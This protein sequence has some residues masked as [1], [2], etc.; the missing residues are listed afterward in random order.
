MGIPR[1]LRNVIFRQILLYHKEIQLDFDLSS[2]WTSAEDYWMFR[3]M[4]SAFDE[5]EPI[6]GNRTEAR[7]G[8][9]LRILRVCKQAY[10]EGRLIFYGDNRWFFRHARAFHRLFLDWPE[11]YTGCLSTKAGLIRDLTIWPSKDDTTYPELSYMEFIEVMCEYLPALQHLQII[12][13]YS[14]FRDRAQDRKRWIGLVGI[15][16]NVVAMAARITRNHPSLKKAIYSRRSGRLREVESVSP[17][18]R[19]FEVVFMV[20]LVPA[21]TATKNFPMVQAITHGEFL[22]DDEE[23]RSDWLVTEDIVLDCQK[24][25][26]AQGKA[27]SGNTPAE[28]ALPSTALSSEPANY[29]SR[30]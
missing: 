26:A 16:H 6:G 25:R 2:N 19:Q 18:M 20:D 5:R 1:E 27:V 9:D 29:H 10:E 22:A 17:R 8:I 12:L 15:N 14:M 3:R 23:P 7:R 13:S 28:F 11:P 4:Q 30:P 24:V 21:G